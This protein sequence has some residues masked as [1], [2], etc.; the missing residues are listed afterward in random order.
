MITEEDIRRR[1]EDAI[2]D[3]VP[4]GLWRYLVAE[5]KVDAVKEAAQRGKVEKAKAVN[6]F[7]DEVL[8]LLE[9]TGRG[10]K[11]R[12]S[13]PMLTA[14]QRQRAADHQTVVAILL[15]REAAAD[16]AVVDFRARILA[17]KLLTSDAVE[18]WLTSREAADGKPTVW[19]QDVVVPAGYELR[20]S[21]A[22][23]T[24]PPLAVTAE[25]PGRPT[26]RMLACALPGRPTVA[27]LT[28][29]G[30][31]LEELR[32]L[33]QRLAREFNWSATQSTHFILTGEV[34]SVPLIQVSIGYSSSRP[35]CTRIGLEVDPTA[36]PQLVAERYRQ[37][38]REVFFRRVRALSVRH[39]KLA[40]FAA[41][42]QDGKSWQA[43]LSEWNRKHPTWKYW[44]RN[45]FKRDCRRAQMRLLTLGQ[46]HRRRVA[47]GRAAVP[48]LSPGR[49]TGRKPP[50]L[51]R[52]TN[53]AR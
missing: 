18:A 23:F 52:Q 51:A 31:V 20:G 34:P 8:A 33:S 4:L 48:R 29:A 6:R 12:Q 49:T 10:P 36:S 38:R 11:S 30:G 41:E 22:V 50:G 3:K 42:R 21:R 27:V 37:A 19:L 16:S 7:T 26:T 46:P 32:Q 40:A 2:G 5:K 14:Q 17:G 13:P 45:N 35:A 47:L 39:L 43:L 15:A 25:H 53:P 28:K 24:V 9:A 44:R 1:V